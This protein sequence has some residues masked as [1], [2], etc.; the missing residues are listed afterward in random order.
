ML[1]N[2]SVT[3][4]AILAFTV[5]TVIGLA[6]NTV[7][8]L[9]AVEAERAVGN[10][11]ELQN[12][13][14]EISKL[15]GVID[16]QSVGLKNFLLT[17]DRDWVDRIEA[18]RADTE[19]LA[20]EIAPMLAY[21]EVAD[22]I[23]D[24]MTKWRQ[25][26]QD[27]VVR[28]IALMRDP[29]TVDLAKAIE[30]AGNGQAA[31]QAVRADIK[32]ALSELAEQQSVLAS[33]QNRALSMVETVAIV[34]AV[35][36]A[37]CAVLFGIFNHLS[38]VRPLGS[39]AKVTQALS[40]GE[41]GMT[42]T[43]VKRADEIG[44]MHNALSI[45][46]AS[47]VRARELETA[48]A[49]EREA[50]NRQRREAM[51]RLADE[52]EASVLSL[53]SEISSASQHLEETAGLLQEVSSSTSEQSL[54]VS[55]AAEQATNNV[56]T[57]ASATE[58]LS[59][60]TRDISAQIEASSKVARTAA[61]EVERSSQA[62]DGL[63]AVVRRIGDV[64]QLITDIASQTNLL[65]LNATI[66]AARAGE[67]GKGFAVVAAEVKALAEQ[68]A[69][70][71]EEINRQI[72]DIRSAADVSIEATQSIAEMVR[73]IAQR[74]DEIAASTEQQNAATSEIARNITEAATGTQEV[75]ASIGKVSE[76]AMRTGDASTE[77]RKSV[78]DLDTRLGSLRGA[79]DQF[80]EN[81][82][83]A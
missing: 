56:Q 52:F 24:A 2:M 46:R 35:I 20:A 53:S 10:Y 18:K 29:M 5:L 68:T 37:L 4:K 6:L 33:A 11:G 72:A 82:R 76:S 42:L 16:D 8:Y 55:S 61:D 12:S 34:S 54:T 13:I 17:G 22:H 59:A 39:L 57:V 1:N 60:S 43:E 40:E 49:E 58:E 65:A 78:G 67:A 77:L 36:S 71:T 30:A 73:D 75:S 32:L 83:A 45:F 47:L 3:L 26:Y 48:S 23:G 79:M 70:A 14:I 31:F 27:F 50:A 69:K 81:V 64:T 9:Q 28:Q 25:W 63:N 62:V 41:T 80:L 21:L 38:V 44:R 51:L 15:E 19:A 74:S 7:I 66:E